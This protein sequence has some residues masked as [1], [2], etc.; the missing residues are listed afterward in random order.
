MFGDPY[1]SVLRSVSLLRYSLL[2]FW[3]TVFFEAHSGGLPVMRP[4][5]LEFPNDPDPNLLTI[6]DQWM[7]GR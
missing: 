2:P 7:V 5:F 4:L 3:Y 1:T 6:D